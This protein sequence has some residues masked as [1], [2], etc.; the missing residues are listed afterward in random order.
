M[1]NGKG[2][3]LFEKVVFEAW[4]P[5]VIWN[6]KFAATIWNS[7]QCYHVIYDEKKEALGHFSKRVGRVGRIESSKEPDQCPR[8]Q[9]WVRVQLALRLLLLMT[10]QRCHLP[11]PLP[12]PVSSSCLFTR[13][14]T[15]Y[16]RC[17]TVL[18]SF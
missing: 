17:C 12:T 5:D 6:M 7:I 8:R 4:D 14:Q 1:R 13:C 9:A 16:A 15:L 10:L 2:F 11:P 3:Y 18:L